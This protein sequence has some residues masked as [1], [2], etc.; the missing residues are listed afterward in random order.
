M[1]KN[2][3]MSMEKQKRGQLGVNVVERI[4]LQDWR[5]RWQPIDSVN[6]DGVDGLIFMESRGVPTGQIVF[7]QVKCTSKKPRS[8][9]VVAVAIKREKLTMNIERWRRV[10]GAAILVHVNPVTLKAY[11]VNLRDENAIG[12]TQ[13]LV[14]SENIFNKSSRK[15]ISKLCG[16]IHRDL[17]IKKLTT[18]G[19]DFPYLK[20]KEHIQVCAR[21]YYKKLDSL[22]LRIGGNGPVVRFTKEGWGH[23]TRFGR[24]RLTQLQS[25]QL[26][27]VV[28][29]MIESTNES[30]LR[31]IKP[32][33]GCPVEFVYLMAAISFPHRQTAVVKIIL[34]RRQDSVNGTNYSFRTIYEPRRRHDVLGVR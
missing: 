33:T 18:K 15:E 29:E 25:F 24:A 13:V 3:A 30:E 20:E 31:E 28:K 12:N 32:E 34:W 26:L 10:V 7:V 27:G 1:S 22:A 19:S 5:G 2:L 11:W 14:P 9:G 16:T 4:V 23:I 8:D 6:D 17:L 21:K